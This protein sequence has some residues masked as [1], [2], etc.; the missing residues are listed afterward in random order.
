[1][2]SLRKDIIPFHAQK[3]QAKKYQKDRKP[4]MGIILYR[5]LV[6]KEKKTSTTDHTTYSIKEEVENFAIILTTIR[7]TELI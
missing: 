3:R 6:W 2:S 5:F 1:M 7:L 4:R